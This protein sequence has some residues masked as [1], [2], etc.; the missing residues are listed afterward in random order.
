MD[1]KRAIEELEANKNRGTFYVEMWDED[2]SENGFCLVDEILLDA[3]LDYLRAKRDGEISERVRDGTP[4]VIRC[5][6]CEYGLRMTTNEEPGMYMCRNNM[7]NDHNRVNYAWWY[8]PL[9]RRRTSN[10]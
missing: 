8:C 10:E 2:G 4:I 7:A 6:D 9:C 1:L 5:E 3:V